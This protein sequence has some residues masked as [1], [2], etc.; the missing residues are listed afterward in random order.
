MKEISIHELKAQL[1][2]A[3]AEA[4]AGQTILITRHKRP[5][6]RLTPAGTQHTHV[7][8]GR[9]AAKL[10]PLLKQATR[11]RYLT[12]LIEDRRGADER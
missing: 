1:S 9:R 11:G 2:A 7:G 6:A 5:V 12:V 3:V 4:E 8:K 10:K